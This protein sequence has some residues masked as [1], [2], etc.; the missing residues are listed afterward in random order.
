MSHCHNVK[1]EREIE[2]REAEEIQKEGVGK[3]LNILVRTLVPSQ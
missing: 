2:E 3:D 1:T